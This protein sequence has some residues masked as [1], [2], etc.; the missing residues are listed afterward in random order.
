MELAL[1]LV[2]SLTHV[3]G[4]A[5]N[6]VRGGDGVIDVHHAGLMVGIQLASDTL[7]VEVSKRCLQDGYIGRP[8]THG[9]LQLSR[10]SS[11]SS[12][13]SPTSPAASKP[14]C[15]RAD[16]RSPKERTRRRGS[17]PRQFGSIANC[18]GGSPFWAPFPAWHRYSAARQR[19]RSLRHKCSGEFQQ[20]PYRRSTPTEMS[21][22]PKSCRH[23]RNFRNF[24][25]P[26]WRICTANHGGVVPA[27]SRGRRSISKTSPPPQ[28]NGCSM[29]VRRAGENRRRRALRRLPKVGRMVREARLQA[30]RRKQVRGRVVFAEFAGRTKD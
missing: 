26:G 8:V 21:F 12:R 14:I 2:N 20:V 29:N 1:D 15:R 4:A 11:R 22:L 27:L 19:Y 17:S 23:Q 25:Q 13:G 3:L 28:G 24:H 6:A 30:E 10:R 18:K 16:R 9:T 5:V 7:A